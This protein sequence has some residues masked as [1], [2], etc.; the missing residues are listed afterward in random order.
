MT[1]KKRKK[2]TVF[3]DILIVILLIIIGVCAFNIGKILYRYYVGTK[4]YHEVAKV[5]KKETA[6]D[7]IDWKALKAKYPDIQA[8][9]Y[10]KDTVI[11]YPVVQGKDNSY[12][13]YRMI[14][15]KYNVKGTLFIDYRVQRPFQDFLTVIYGHRMKDKSMFWT[16]ADYRDKPEYYKQHPTMDLSTPTQN[17]TLQIF[18]ACTIPAN[19][20]RYEFDF[21]EEKDK[22]FYLKWIRENSQ[23]E[24]DIQVTTSD[25]IV[26]L[27]TC[28]YEYDNARAVVFGKLVPKK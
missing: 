17:Y 8:W 18:A 22:A 27:S 15:G 11:N 14:N 21:P 28:T 25:K 7:K 5:A 24:T 20:A 1:A 10:Q 13:L 19:S 6:E 2:S 9:L 26:M 23:L 4:Q 12:Y 3:L 16:I